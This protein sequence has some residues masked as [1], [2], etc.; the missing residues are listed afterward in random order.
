MLVAFGTASNFHDYRGGS[1]RFAVKVSG[2]TDVPMNILG[3]LLA[4]TACAEAHFFLKVATDGADDYRPG[5]LAHP[6]D[7]FGRVVAWAWLTDPDLAIGLIAD[8][9]A[10]ARYHDELAPEPGKRLLLSD[11]LDGLPLTVRPKDLPEPEMKA[12]VALAAERVP[13]HFGDDVNAP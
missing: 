9:V 1:G 3:T 5:Q 7:P 12:L 13:S 8:F 4:N 2:M 10:Q 11:L 6:G